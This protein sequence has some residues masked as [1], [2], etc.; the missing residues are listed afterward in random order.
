MLG[1]GGGDLLPDSGPVKV[2]ESGRRSVQGEV[3][4]EPFE[5]Q[6]LVLQLA[7]PPGL[8]DLEAAVL[9][10]PPAK[11]LPTDVQCRRQSSVVFAPASASSRCR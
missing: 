1:S 8:V 6:I 10:L 4:D 9:G 3:G 2:T 11:R 7:Q 5:P